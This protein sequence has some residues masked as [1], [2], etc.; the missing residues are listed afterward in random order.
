MEFALQ[1]REISKARLASIV[2]VWAE[3]ML[4]VWLVVTWDNTMTTSRLTNG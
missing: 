3:A 4:E 2:T 1:V